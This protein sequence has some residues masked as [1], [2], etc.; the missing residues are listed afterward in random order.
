[1][2]KVLIYGIGK[3]AQRYFAD[4]KYWKHLSEYIEIVGVCD[5]DKEKQGTSIEFLGKEWCIETLENFD[6]QKVDAVLCTVSA[7]IFE[8]IKEQY[9]DNEV[10][11]PK[12]ARFDEYIRD[13]LFNI[14][15]KYKL[16]L[17]L[18]IK[19]E[20]SYIKEWIEFH[21]L[22]GV[23]HIYLYDN[24]STDCLYETIEEYIKEGFVTYHYWDKGKNQGEVYDDAVLRYKNET[25]YM[26]FIDSDEFLFSLVDENLSTTLNNIVDKYERGWPR[27]S[28]MHCG[29]I[30]INWRV[31]GTSGHK[32]RPKG[33]VIQNYLFRG[34]DCYIENVHIKSVV[35][36]RVVSKCEIHHM[37]YYPGFQCISE[38]GTAIYEPFFPERSCSKL[39]INH[40]CSK[41]E[42]D[43]WLKFNRGW[44]NEDDEDDI[45]EKY[46]ERLKEL[47]V[48]NEIYDPIMLKYMNKLKS[49]KI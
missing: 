11:L 26:G 28:E 27:Y 14:P 5:G 22:V 39:R 2:K 37:H 44:L 16:S 45:L 41:S 25:K 48:C 40:Y 8:K 31:Y 46:N 23:E 3:F 32:I 30:G 33:F 15:T 19:N 38:N 20:S 4:E 18:I 21:R 43:L 10:I 24:E 47:E 35:N 17:V 6:I 36:P 42:E 34:K 12:L 29:G 13:C 1:M 7:R 49:R 9:K